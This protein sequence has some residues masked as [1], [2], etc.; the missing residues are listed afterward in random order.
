[1]E[2]NKQLQQLFQMEYSLYQTYQMMQSVGENKRIQEILQQEYKIEYYL[3]NQMNDINTLTILYNDVSKKIKEYQLNDIEAILH[4]EKDTIVWRRLYHKLNWHLS[5]IRQ[6]SPLIFDDLGDQ[7][8]FQNV[9]LMEQLNFQQ[10]K[11]FQRFIEEFLNQEVS[12]DDFVKEKIMEAKLAMM[13][14][15]HDEWEYINSTNNY[16]YS[17]LN[18]FSQKRYI[19]GMSIVNQQIEKMLSFKSTDDD[20]NRQAEILLRQSFLRVGLS[21]LSSEQMQELVDDFYTIIH[22][23]NSNYAS[24]TTVITAIS[25]AF[26]WAENDKKREMG[27]QLLR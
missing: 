9:V 2:L 10:N 12:L 22:L 5:R 14:L 3:L 21:Y 26:H 23:D 13:Y 4:Q 25:S 20:V 8:Q 19:V 17:N 27:P 11:L 16:A 7:T 24:R 18:F 1:M 15:F 6:S